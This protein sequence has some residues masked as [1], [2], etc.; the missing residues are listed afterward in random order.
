VYYGHVVDCDRGTVGHALLLSRD[1]RLGRW[2]EKP[3]EKPL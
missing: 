3:L 1:D 2:L